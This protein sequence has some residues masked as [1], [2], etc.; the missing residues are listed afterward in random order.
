MKTRLLITA[1]AT[2]A[3]LMGGTSSAAAQ[4]FRGH[5]R[6][7]KMHRMENR[8]DKHRSGPSHFD[9]RFVTHRPSMGARFMHR[10]SLGRFVTIDRERLLLADGVLYREVRTPNG[11]V[12]IVVGYI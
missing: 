2:V 6:G 11:F 3:M 8:F 12:Y 7:G 1:F 4:G 5:D 9:N 10:P